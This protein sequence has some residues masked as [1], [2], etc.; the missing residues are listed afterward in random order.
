MVFEK[1]MLKRIFG[2][3]WGVVTGGWRT[4]HSEELDDLFFSPR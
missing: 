1:G 3:K 4:L 2:S